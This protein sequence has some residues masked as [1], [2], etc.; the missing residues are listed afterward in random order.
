MLNDFPRII[1]AAKSR[2]RLLRGIVWFVIAVVLFGLVGFLVLPPLARPALERSLSTALDRKVTIERLRVNPFAVSATLNNVTVGERGEGPPL[3]TLPEL[4]MHAGFAGLSSLFRWAPVISELRL[5]Q[6]YLHIV[7]NEDKSYNVSDFIDQALAPGPTPRFS[8]S[9]IQVINGSID[10]DDRPEH[11]VHKVT[12]LNIGIPFLSSLPTQAD[13]K[14]EP[15]FSALVNGRAVA[16]TGETQPFEDTH[17][18]VLHW[19]IQDLSLPFY[20]DYLPAKLPAKVN[21][22]RLDASVDLTFI[23]RGQN[24]PQFTLAGDF[25]L[26]DLAVNERSGEPLLRVPS[27]IVGVDRLDLTGD[28]AEL[29][30]IAAHGIEVDARRASDGEL[31]FASLV[32]PRGAPKR[33]AAPFRFHVGSIALDHAVVRIADASV[34]PAF[35]AAL[36]DIKLDV[37]NLSSQPAQKATAALTLATD[38]GGHL[39]YR[40]TIGLSPMLADGQLEFTGIRLGLL[41]PYYASALNLAVDDG[42]L[43]VSSG[44]RFDEPTGLALNN[45]AAT[46]HNLTMRLPDDKQ[47]LWRV[48][49]LAGAGG[50]V[51][52]S[53]QAVHF[54]SLESH[55]A[56]ATIRRDAGGEFNFDRIIRNPAAGAHPSASAEGWRFEAGKVK[57]DDFS[58]TFTD[59]SVTPPAR[60]SLTRIAGSAEN[61]SNGAKEKGRATLQMTVNKRGALTLSGPLATAPFAASLNVVAKNID[62]VPFQPYI[63]RSVRVVLTGGAVSAHGAL[64]V[65][66]AKGLHGG[67]KGDV[68]ASD[69]AALDEANETDL[70]KW[71]SLA[72]NGIDARFGPLAVTIGEIALNDFYARLLLNETGEFNLQQLARSPTTAPAPPTPTAGTKTVELA[73]SPGAGTPWLKLGK[74]TMANGRIYFT[75][76]FIRPNYSADLSGMAGSLSTLAFDQPADLELRGK[77]QE[78]AE[79]RI[80][81]RINPLAQ[82]L[83]LDLKADASDIELPPMTPYSDKYVGYGIQKGKLSMKVHYLIDNRKLTAENTVVLDQ[84]TFGEKVESPDAI[85]VPVLLA[86]ALL[87]DRNGV[88]Q[89]D[90][91]ISGSLD[92]PQFSVGGLVFRAIVNLLVKIV[93]S[94]FA[95]LGAL[96]GHGEELA[97]IEF[98]PGSAALDAPSEEKIK[99]VAKALG[100]RPALK[101]DIAG[102]VDPSADREGLKHAT[103]DHEIRLQK[104]DELK[105]HGEPPS[106]VDAVE[107]K[108]DE[109]DGLLKQ[110]Y[111]DAN[112]AKPRNAIGLPQDLPPAE[113]EALLLANAKVSDEDL[114][115]LAGRRAQTVQTRLAGTEHVPVERM[116]LVEP[117]LDAQGIKDKGKATRVDFALH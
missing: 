9:N 101:L 52:V 39:S 26:A 18:T 19:H 56:V 58:A 109:R 94:P 14:V 35:A 111:K 44:I 89:F 57:L 62:L 108:A 34:K 100:D 47:P 32:P 53:K 21:S 24:P 41:Y 27:L 103:I 20:L 37:S 113:M 106:S 80:T 71:Q 81:G 84:L 97:Y 29:R 23:G 22:G 10:F 66:T 5:T 54:D 2:P 61:I 30:T 63:A 86:V 7:R 90:L 72:L 70:L 82:N 77:V 60:I 4:Y 110:V 45:L 6:P 115:Q 31:N 11:K 12:D 92:D 105:R 65:D 116:F 42:A 3:A 102:R 85:K 16:I 76:H 1:T 96:G 99:A 33:G 36:T 83:F 74:A 117:K 104:F 55:G 79:V 28:S 98:A 91:P 48:P 75:D 107:V 43:D 93:T 49:V 59:E 50:S 95:L 46:I 40:G 69:V 114:R 38:G 78:S 8:V 15:T 25:E 13:I 68:L 112:F 67:F 17:Q 64:D 88:I 51:D 73:A 87:K